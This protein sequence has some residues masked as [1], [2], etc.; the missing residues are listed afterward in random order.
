[1]KIQRLISLRAGHQTLYQLN[2]S[3]H[4]EIVLFYLLP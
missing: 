2:R 4:S 3:S 1:M